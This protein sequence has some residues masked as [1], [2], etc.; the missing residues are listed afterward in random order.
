MKLSDRLLAVASFVPKNSIVVDVGTDHGY[1][2]AYLIKNNISK[3]IIATDISEESLNKCKNYIKSLSLEGKIDTRVGDGFEVLKPFEVDTAII[4]GMGGLLITDIIDKRRDISKSITY[5]I[6]QP[7]I[8]SDKLRKYLY[9]NSF[10]IIDEKLVKEGEKF[11]EIIF[12]K[13]GKS[14][15]EKEIYFEIGEKLIKKKDPLLEE[16]ISYKINT[17]KEIL[18]KLKD[19]N[20]AKS[21]ERK[22]VLIKKLA[23][24][25]EV[26]EIVKS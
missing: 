11:Y 9:E 15:I 25:R 23:E 5:F 21:I 12:A 1:I 16:F 19:K 4:A 10:E 6:I 26:L 8:A 7:M 20:T 17:A 13:H 18:D 2:P 14:Y 22:N 3:K 24:Y